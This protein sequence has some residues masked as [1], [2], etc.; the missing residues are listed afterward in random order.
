VSSTRTATVRPGHLSAAD[1]VDNDRAA[2]IGR[3][4]E[5]ARLEEL[6]ERVGDR[7]HAVVLREKLASAN[8][9]CSKRHA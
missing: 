7:G 8:R 4:R 1:D 5:S 9:R 6:L 2:L 3:E